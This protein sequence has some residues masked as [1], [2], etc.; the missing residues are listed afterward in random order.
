MKCGVQL[1]QLAIAT[2]AFS[3]DHN[4]FLPASRQGQPNSWVQS[5]WTEVKSIED[6][7]IYSYTNGDVEAYQCPSFMWFYKN[8]VPEKAALTYSMNE[9]IGNSWHGVSVMRKESV[10]SASDFLVLTDENWFVVPGESTHAI[11]NGALGVGRYDDPGNLIDAIGSFHGKTHAM[12]EGGGLS[13]VAFLDEH[14]SLHRI[15]ETKELATPPEA[16]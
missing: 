2:D 1:R 4:G 5:P 7:S 6:G 3:V 16:R 9:Y 8:D 12:Y 15:E 13:N 10:K 14:V 11:N